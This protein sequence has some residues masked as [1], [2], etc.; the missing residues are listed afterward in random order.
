[1]VNGALTSRILPQ[2]PSGSVVS[3]PR[4]Q[5]DVVITEFGIAEL[6]GKTIRERSRALA[7]ISHPQFRDELLASAEQWPKD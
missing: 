2:F 5:I 6:E 4:H 7:Q 3:T 1:M